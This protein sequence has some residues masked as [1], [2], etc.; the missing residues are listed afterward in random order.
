DERGA[1]EK[2]DVRRLMRGLVDD[3]AGSRAPD[4]GD[5]RR[6]RPALPQIAA[7]AVEEI[8]TVRV[9]RVEDDITG[10]IAVRDDLWVRV[11]ARMGDQGGLGPARSVGERVRPED[12]ARDQVVPGRIDSAV[13]VDGEA[14]SAR[15]P[16][17]VEGQRLRPRV[18]E[19]ERS[20]EGD[21]VRRF[22]W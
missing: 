18:P 19:I 2:R 16:M 21:P 8:R 1:P 10:V 6:C 20:L 5:L 4:T 9:D 14:G 11:S 15:I 3:D 17:L 12:R 13:T 22:S 7:G